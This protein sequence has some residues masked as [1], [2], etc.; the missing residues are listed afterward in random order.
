ME[1]ESWWWSPLKY[2]LHGILFS[3][4][5][6]VLAFFWALIFAVLVVL[7][8]FIGFIIGFVVLFFIIGGL[9]SFLTDILWDI[10]IK[11]E[12]KSLLGHGFVM[13]ILLIIVGIPAVVINFV[14]PSVAT[15]ILLFF[16]Y[17]F[18]D[19]FVAKNV[20]GWWEEELEER[21]I[22]IS[23]THFSSR[24]LT[25]RLTTK[26]APPT[27]SALVSPSPTI[28]IRLGLVVPILRPF[29]VSSTPQ[30]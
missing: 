28:S 24:L 14:V 16:I 26:S 19:G 22:E 10:S 23:D 1:E 11:T 13:F 12:W 20:A 27:T 25:K 18:I 21:G 4:I 7:G 17:A 29:S 9:N 15:T 5:F 6:F 2:F 30:P 8:L 3:V